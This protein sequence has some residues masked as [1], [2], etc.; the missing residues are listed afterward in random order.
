[1]I[2]LG[3]ESV[4]LNDSHTLTNSIDVAVTAAVKE[5]GKSKVTEDVCNARDALLNKASALTK[6]SNVPYK[7]R[8][9]IDVASDKNGSAI[10]NVVHGKNNAYEG[11][12]VPLTEEE[13]K[14]WEAAQLLKS[15]LFSSGTDFL[16]GRWFSQ[17]GATERI[18]QQSKTLEVEAA[19][20]RLGLTPLFALWERQHKEYG[21]RM[22]FTEAG[23][24]FAEL[25]EQWDEALEVYYA[26]V[27]AK[28]KRGSKLRN[29]LLAPY[30]RL[31]EELRTLRR[32]VRQQAQQSKAR[33]GE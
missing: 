31:E 29:R 17:Y 2:E 30:L 20:Q 13:Q 7:E 23:L 8:R 19:I 11:A 33:V 25:F 24:S 26:M 9:S 5:E 21:K 18:L 16:H 10:W 4:S 32:R 27:I 1:M 14:E 28:H 15:E 6:A 22:G 12:E 3:L